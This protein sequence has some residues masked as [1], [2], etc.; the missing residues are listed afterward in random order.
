ML[1]VAEALDLVWQH[2][3][4]LTPERVARDRALGLMLAE[5]IS[6]D[7]D[8]PPHDKSI[9]DGY[10]VVAA[11]LAGGSAELT[12]LEEVVAGAMPTQRV[13]PGAATRIMTGAPLPDGADAVVM[14]ERTETHADAGGSSRVVIRVAPTRAGQNIMRRGASLV[15]G[16]IV[17]QAGHVLRPIE[18]GLLAE[19]GRSELLAIP[20]PTLAVLSTGDELVPA[21]QT[22]GPSQIRNSNEPLLV[23]CAERAGAL[24]RGLGIGRDNRA[25]LRRLIAAGL[26]SNVLVLSG[27]VSAGVL[28]LV[29]SVLAE[30]GVQQVF[31]KVRLKPGKPVWFGVLPRDGGRP[32]TLVFGLPG[33]PVSSFV[34]F[35]LFVRA[36][37]AALAGHRRRPPASL[38]ATLASEYTHRGD[39]PTF[40]PSVLHFQDDGTTVEPLDWAGSSDLAGLA[41]A[42]ALAC[43]PAGNSTHAAGSTVDILR[44]E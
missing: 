18:I 25:D 20:R 26:E 40:H 29:P 13:T 11:D 42:N 33:N 39:R 15:R 7:V 22:P 23:A 37:L 38:R 21:D 12:I 6:S 10:A 34:C 8:S 30:L 9:V 16:Q 24:P 17:L 5:D 43:F 36:A 19:V 35:E 32:A 4:P 31:H 28:D 2:A 14:I 27:G 3:T 1:S 41:R 44:L